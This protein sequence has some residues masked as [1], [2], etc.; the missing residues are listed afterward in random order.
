MSAR[1]SRFLFVLFVLIWIPIGAGFGQLSAPWSWGPVLGA[2]GEDFVAITWMT[3]R[4]VGFDLRYSLA[5]V[6]DATGQWDETLTFERY[7]G[8]AEIWLQDLMP[9][10]S[11]RYQLIFYEG[12]AVYPT[13]VGSFR[14]FEQNARSFSFAV[15]GATRSFP[16]RHKLVADAI[17]TSEAVSLVF[18]AG[19]LVDTP[20]E[21]HFDN[22]FW[23][24]GD[25]ARS[26]PFV[27][28]IGGRDSDDSF[29]F[30]YLALPVGG[31]LDDEQ[32]WS[33]DYGN[34]H[35]V[36]VDSTLAESAN[37]LAMRAQTAWL[38]DD[39]AQVVGKLIVVF[40]NDALYSAS[41][42]DGKNKAL[43]SAWESLFRYY[44]VDVVFSASEACY[45][46]VYRSGVHYVNAGGGGAPLIPAPEAIAPGTVCRR[47]GML[48]YIRCTLADDSLLIEAIPVASVIDDIIYLVPSGRSIDTVLLRIAE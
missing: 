25:L 19:G 4:A 24:I 37:D 44:G 45:E 10:S 8:V 26:N 27:S 43:C 13:E 20:T 21:E 5:Q 17:A 30:D 46:H 48:H 29:Y 12:D 23:A 6:Y 28:V 42:A 34:I 9:G 14:T 31:G 2:V 16:D 7:E 41:Y 18:H 47:Y 1:I 11:Y 3:N 32:W 39:L 22:F 38:E 33:F 15:Y 40:S 36:G 35:F